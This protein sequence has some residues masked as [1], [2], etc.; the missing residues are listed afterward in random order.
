MFSPEDESIGDSDQVFSGGVTISQVLV[1]PVSD[2]TTGGVSIAGGFPSEVC[3]IG[4]TTV[5]TVVFPAPVTSSAIQLNPSALSATFATSISNPLRVRFFRVQSL[6]CPV[7]AIV[8]IG[9][10][11][12]GVLNSTWILCFHALIIAVPAISGSEKVTRASNMTL[13]LKVTRL[14]NITDRVK[15]TRSVKTVRISIK[16]ES[17]EDLSIPST[18][19]SS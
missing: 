8:T 18:L 4:S 19:T 1:T 12:Y 9:F 7:V 17:S 15:V 3:G 6:K 10:T 16:S 11:S 14:S 5:G 13:S 2:V